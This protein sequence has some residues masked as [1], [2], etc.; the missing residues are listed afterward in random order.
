MCVCVHHACVCGW[1][2]GGAAPMVATGGEGEGLDGESSQ[3]GDGDGEA[4][5][6]A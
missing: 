2:R 6:G 3:R 5:A 1:A 4:T